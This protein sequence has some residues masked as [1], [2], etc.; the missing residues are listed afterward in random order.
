MRKLLPIAALLASASLCAPAAHA[1]LISIGLQQA[2]TNSGAVTTVA[3]DGGSGGVSYSGAYGSFTLNQI[4]ASGSPILAAPNLDSGAIN[5]SDASGGTITVYVTES[6]LS[7]PLGVNELLSAFTSNLFNGDVTS[8]VETTYIGTHNEMF[9][10]TEL[11]SRSFNG[12]ATQTFADFTP[13][14]TSPYSETMEYVI[15]T[16]GAADVNDTIDIAVPEPAS[17][18]LLGSGLLALGLLLRRRSA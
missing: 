18:A 15:T 10:G 16:T 9:G 17:V 13:S 6:G 4:Q 7:S 12:I 1:S 2:N 8:V 5:V 11:A 14:L 3:T